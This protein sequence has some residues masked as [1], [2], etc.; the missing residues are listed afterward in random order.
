LLGRYYFE[1]GRS[2]L[3]YLRTQCNVTVNFRGSVLT[4]VSHREGVRL[5]V[6]AGRDVAARVLAS[7]TTEA[8]DEILRVRRPRPR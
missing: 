7:T 5:A 8:H 4:L 3:E 1:H 2:E 6:D